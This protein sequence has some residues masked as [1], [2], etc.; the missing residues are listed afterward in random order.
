[1]RRFTELPDLL[2]HLSL[3][4][5]MSDRWV[6]D[7][8]H[9]PYVFR[10]LSTSGYALKSSFA[11][12]GCDANIEYHLLRNFRRY[13]LT[14]TR[15]QAD[16]PLWDLLSLAQHHGLPT[17]LLDW[18]FSPL[19]ALHF[20]TCSLE[21]SETDGALWCVDVD[22]VHNRERLPWDF[23]HEL[24]WVES[25]LF[26]TRMLTNIM[27]NNTYEGSARVSIKRQLEVLR[28]LEKVRTAGEAEEKRSE[29]RVV[30]RKSYGILE[31]KE[32]SAE[33]SSGILTPLLHD[34]KDTYAV[35]FEPPSLDPR[36]VSQY[37]LFSFLSD[38]MQD[39]DTWLSSRFGTKY[40]ND[41]LPALDS[42]AQ[43]PPY[44]KLVIDSRLKPIV[45][46]FLDQASINERTM[47]PDQD[48]LAAWLKRHYTRRKG[49]P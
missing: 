18:T 41:E 1:M 5:G 13:Y 17:R 11:R 9:S 39:L 10:G 30:R 44:E 45:R 6:L 29:I 47:F 21:R 33:D 49:A 42:L 37:A 31:A 27:L 46:R 36:I 32:V 34:E 25:S 16:L 4:T 28:D 2:H 43:L 22:A 8:H 24:D 19:V 20:A 48:G 12:L 14:E 38:P 3:L 7:N 15:P 23:Q 40:R 35:F 26:S